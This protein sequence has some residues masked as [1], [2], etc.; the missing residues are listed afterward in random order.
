MK[1]TQLFCLMGPTRRSFLDADEFDPNLKK[2]ISIL[3]KFSYD[4]LLSI[5]PKKTKDMVFQ[6]K[7]RNNTKQILLSH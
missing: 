7:C 2:V 6:Q 4:W 3:E 1:W 5:N